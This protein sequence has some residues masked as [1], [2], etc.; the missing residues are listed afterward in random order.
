MFLFLLFITCEQSGENFC[1]LLRQN[2]AIVT[3]TAVALVIYKG[4]G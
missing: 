1:Q 2:F 3:K 4:D